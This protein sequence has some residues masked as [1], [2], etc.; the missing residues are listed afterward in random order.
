MIAARS[1]GIDAVLAHPA[2]RATAE[3]IA[4]LVRQQAEAITLLTQLDSDH[5]PLTVRSLRRQLHDVTTHL[6]TAQALLPHV[7]QLVLG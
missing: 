5:A 4:E 1:S 2:T 6:A 7:H 3:L